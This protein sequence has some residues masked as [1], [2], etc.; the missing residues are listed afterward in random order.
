M[1]RFFRAEGDAPLRHV[2]SWLAHAISAEREEPPS[3][4]GSARMRLLL[5]AA[6]LA[7]T[8]AVP[9]EHLHEHSAD[10]LA[11]K[12]EVPPP[13][14]PPPP[15]PRPVPRAPEMIAGRMVRSTSS[16]IS[17][18]ARDLGI[19]CLRRSARSKRNTI[20]GMTR[21]KASGIMQ[22]SGGELPASGVRITSSSR[23]TRREWSLE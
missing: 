1:S 17:S 3:F 13:P 23:T 22:T 20:A 16:S 8:A 12:R 18:E 2:A 7:Q 15:P 10:E 5:V 4:F 9:V 6:V 19:S 14:P 11:E 21:A